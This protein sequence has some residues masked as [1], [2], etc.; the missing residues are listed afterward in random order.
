M[1][2]LS[3]S[4]D[5]NCIN[6]VL[7]FLSIKLKKRH[8]RTF[9]CDIDNSNIYSCAPSR[10]ISME[11]VITSRSLDETKRSEKALYIFPDDWKIDS[12]NLR[13]VGRYYQPHT[14]YCATPYSP[15]DS[16]LYSDTTEIASDPTLQM[17]I[18]SD[19]LYSLLPVIDEDGSDDCN[20]T[21][22]N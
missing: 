8:R 18:P 20:L 22:Q 2:S 7:Y 19:N 16:I 21:L 5:S 10:E 6:K 3:K 14:D 15:P 1:E 4:E 12:G 13:R 17:N 11:H 9:S